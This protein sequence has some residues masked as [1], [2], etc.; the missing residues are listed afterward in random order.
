MKTP[1][2]LLFLIC[3]LFLASCAT[4]YLV[5][6]N[7]FITPES[8]GGAF[9]IKT[10]I[11]QTNAAL[12]TINTDNSTV[13]DG[14]YY[15]EILRTGYLFSGSFSEQFDFV[16]SHIGEG[17]SMLGGKFQ[18]IGGS[19]SSKSAGHK[20]ALAALFGGNEHETVDK[21]VE[22]ELTGNE[23]LFLY[24]YRINEFVHPYL[25][26]SYATYNFS[27]KINISNQSIDGL[28]PFFT[29]NSHSLSSGLELTYES[30]SGKVEMTY[31]ELLTTDTNYKGR[32]ILGYSLGWT[33]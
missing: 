31:Q 7:R 21:S 26:I 28:E 19:Q 22:F 12:M 27:G 23:F 17:N 10:E 9:I 33:W 20:M 25:S 6:G 32:L 29:T 8:E 13:D 1:N 14:V 2:F 11:Q 18:F 5:A 3:Q 15:S 24:G 30:L 4:K 16:W